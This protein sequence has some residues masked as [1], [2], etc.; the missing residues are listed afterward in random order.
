MLVAVVVVALTKIT[1]LS[2]SFF[3]S[4]GSSDKLTGLLESVCTNAC[5]SV[6]TSGS[7]SMTFFF[8]KQLERRACEESRCRRLIERGGSLLLLLLSFPPLVVA[9]LPSVG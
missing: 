5:L 9:A 1:P 7:A 6:L 3:R 2:S 8:R 4:L